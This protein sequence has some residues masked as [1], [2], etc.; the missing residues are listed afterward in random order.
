MRQSKEMPTE[1]QFVAMWSNDSE[2]WSGVFKWINGKL[3]RYN[4]FEEDEFGISE[5]P[6]KYVTGLIYFTK[7]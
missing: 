6:G 2:I 5:I 3:Y 4:I 1:G 7:E